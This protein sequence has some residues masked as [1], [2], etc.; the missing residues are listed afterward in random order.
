MTKTTRKKESPALPNVEVSDWPNL[1]KNRDRAFQLVE[2]QEWRY[3]FQDLTAHRQANLERLARTD[4]E[5]TADKIRGAI[6]AIE[7]VLGLPMA[8]DNW[9][10]Q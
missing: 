10:K 1:Y 6:K 5:K 3:F 7:F 8:V 4:D 2:G 9:K